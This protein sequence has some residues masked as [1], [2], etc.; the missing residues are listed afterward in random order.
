LKYYEQLI[1]M[2]CFTRQDVI[3]LT[4]DKGA[5]HSLLYN[6]IK[7]GLVQRVRRDLYV[8][9]SLET[10]QSVANRYAIASHISE[11]A[12][13]THHSVFEY[14]GYANQVFYEVYVSADRKF[15][16]FEFDDLTYH[17]VMPHTNK[18]VEEKTG[19]I[20]VTD[21]ERTVIDSINDFEKIGGLEEL[22]R[23][24]DLIPYLNADK[25]LFYLEQYG[26]GFLYQKTG[27]VLGLFKESLKLPDDFFAR[28]KS[29][30]PKSKRYFYH[31]LQ[32]EQK[33]LNKNWQLFV[34]T[35]LISIIS[36]GGSDIV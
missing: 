33:V 31:G 7:K 22:L 20:R 2:G 19:G 29:Q 32:Y 36:E 21:L 28:C 8:A 11:G 16:T 12:Y 23:C 15:N 1:D 30:L 25:L 9:M 6:Y 3:K 10:K 26:K 18:G 24:I 17:F 34:P 5:A 13:I 14:Y 27:Y 4:G 35:D